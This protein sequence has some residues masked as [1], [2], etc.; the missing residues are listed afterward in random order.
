MR[1]LLHLWIVPAVLVLWEVITRLKEDPFFLP[2]TKIVAHMHEV[3]F[4]GPPQRLFLTD[5]AIGNILPSLQRLLLGWLIACVLGVLLG[6]AIGRS[7]RLGD[8]VDPL[9]NFLRAIPPPVLVPVFIAIFT[10]GAEMQLATI[11]FGVVWPVLLNSI[12]GARYIER[13]YFETCDVFRFSRSVRLFRVIIPAAL[14]KIFAG[15]RLSMSTALI[16][17]IIS[18]LVGS[19][20]GIGYLAML[21]QGSMDMGGLWSSIVLLGILGL[22]LNFILLR[23][24]RRV[25][26]WHHAA[27]T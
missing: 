12:D 22:L 21:A 4:S 17:M 26:T 13:L 5:E 18:E 2:P 14:P 6:V 24:E 8:Y 15:L 25:L 16:L 20:D 11:V 9:I 19:T 3:W 10:I 23:V 7:R 27:R 1:R